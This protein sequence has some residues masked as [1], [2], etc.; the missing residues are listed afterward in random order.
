[1]KGREE[2]YEATK[3]DISF[4]NTPNNNNN[5]M[6]GGVIMLQDNNKT[7]AIEI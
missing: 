3:R 1:V 5:N 7:N 2:R 4:C 6:F